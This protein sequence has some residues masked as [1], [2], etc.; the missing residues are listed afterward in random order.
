MPTRMIFDYATGPQWEFGS[1]FVGSNCSELRQS[2][3][4]PY[5]QPAL[6][7]S[8][9]RQRWKNPNP[10]PAGNNRVVK[11]IC[12]DTPDEHTLLAGLE[13]TAS[14]SSLECKNRLFL[15]KVVK[16][17]TCAA[18]YCK[19]S[20][21]V[22]SRFGTLGHPAR[23]ITTCSI[24]GF[25]LRGTPENLWHPKCKLEFNPAYPAI[26]QERFQ[27]N[28]WQVFYRDAKEAIPVNATSP[29]VSWKPIWQ[30]TWPIVEAK[31][32]ALSKV[33]SGSVPDKDQ[34]TICLRPSNRQMPPPINWN[35]SVY[36]IMDIKKTGGLHTNNDIIELSAW[37][38]GTDS[39]HANNH[40]AF[41]RSYQV[42]YTSTDDNG[43]SGHTITKSTQS[44]IIGDSHVEPV[45]EA[46][47][48]LN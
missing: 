25:T 32:W 30:G 3:K 5:R 47:P 48:R 8:T 2:N 24:P 9:R 29:K 17:G 36:V 14:Y 18:K 7:A 6:H 33:K 20:P 26:D 42:A 4:A 37:L 12:F 22:G 44:Y 31:Q 46:L 40:S 21:E 45:V 10:T 15:D 35:E 41:W 13:P 11:D 38:C 39:F 19:N 16:E 1:H 27:K 43:S 23:D 28:D 34:D